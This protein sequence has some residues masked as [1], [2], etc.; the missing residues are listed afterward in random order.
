MR[1]QG[2][3]RS[4]LSRRCGARF[5]PACCGRTS[6]TR[7]ASRLQDA[8][9]A[10]SL[11]RRGKG[12]GAGSRSARADEAASCSAVAG[13]RNG[14]PRHAPSACR[15]DAGARH[16]AC[17]R[18][19]GVRGHLLGRRAS[20]AL[21]AGEEGACRGVLASS[22]STRWP[23]TIGRA[24]CVCATFSSSPTRGRWTTRRLLSGNGWL[25]TSWPRPTPGRSRSRL[26]AA[27]SDQ[28]ARRLGASARRAQARRFG[29]A[30]QPAQPQ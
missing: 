9:G 23:S 18:V 14:A 19:G 11:R 3:Q 13:A 5:S 27:T 30:P 28:Q 20:A 12:S 4:R 8:S 2:L 15:R 24:R 22:T 1:A 17:R 21:R 7:T 6:S 16:S 26:P 10:R 25:I 29:P